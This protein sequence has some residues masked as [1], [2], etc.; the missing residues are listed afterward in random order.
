M[1]FTNKWD[2]EGRIQEIDSK[3]E[4]SQIDETKTL[5]FGYGGSGKS[6]FVN[7]MLGAEMK[8]VKK[9]GVY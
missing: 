1:D 2:L 7:Y 4:S 5:L 3:I 6:T 9:R 8:W